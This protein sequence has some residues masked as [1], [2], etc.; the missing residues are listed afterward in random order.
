MRVFVTGASGYIGQ[1]VAKAFRSKGHTVYGLVRTQEDAN[2]LSLEEIWPIVGDLSNPDSYRKVLSEVEV[3]VHCAFDATEKGIERDAKTIDTILEVFSGSS[4]PRTFIYTSGV[5]VYGSAGNKIVDESTPLNPLDV[6]KWR[7]EHEEKILKA[8]GPNLRTVILRPGHV[9]GYVGGLTKAILT[10]TQNGSVLI[11]GEGH[12]RWPMVHVQDLAHAY[13]SAAEKELSNV[14]FNVVDDSTTT[15]R[16][17]AEAVAKAAHIEGKFKILSLEEAEHQF[18]PF[19][20]GVA[21]DLTVDN[22]R[23]KRLLG[24]KIH[25]A[26]FINDVEVYYNAWHATQQ[27]DEF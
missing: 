21:V 16:E 24:W 5:W 19:V 20:K 11:V 8:T 26:P 23:I 1:A 17:I 3:A 12:N 9:Y 27:E 22:S 15:L 25:H 4:L 7:P 10:S 13:V 14:I 2:A 18:G 6:V